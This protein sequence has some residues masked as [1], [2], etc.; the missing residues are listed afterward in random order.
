MALPSTSISR[1]REHTNLFEGQPVHETEWNN[2]CARH[3]L[4]VCLFNFI[5]MVPA[6]M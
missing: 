2:S 4:F 3:I 5:T 1:A 6:L